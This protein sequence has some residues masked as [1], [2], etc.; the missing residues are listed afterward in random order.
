MKLLFSSKRVRKFFRHKLAATSMMFL[1][2][3]FSWSIIFPL[4]TPYTP[5]SIN[6]TNRYIAPCTSHLLG[7]DRIGRDV[8]SLLAYG[9]QI[10]L[11]VIFIVGLIT[12]IMGIIVGLI[13]GYIGG[14]IDLIL[15][16]ITEII[17]IVPF[18]VVVLV[19]MTFMPPGLKSV[20]I[21]L[22]LFAWPNTARI[23][24]G[25][26]LSLREEGYVLAAKALGGSNL[27]ILFRHILPGCIPLV[28]VTITLQSAGFVLTE[29]SLSY[30]GF[31]V[32]PPD[33]SWGVML[34]TS[35]DISTLVYRP[36]MWLPAGGM[37]VLTVLA[38]NF[39]GDG[40]RD[41][42]AMKGTKF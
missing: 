39:I 12:A 19:F 20:L 13:S 6:L 17:M 9:G 5:K 22:S 16:R 29:A 33:T 8:L 3:L 27:R 30:L 18:L 42:L 1:F 38:I 40:L 4:M 10:S 2:V 24:R 36:W 28:I 15:Q 32:Q 11:Q 23:V 35:Q 26:V 14:L 31:G 37:L 41:A 34:A 25:E 7:T 21:A